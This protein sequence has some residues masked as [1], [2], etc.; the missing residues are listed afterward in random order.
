MPDEFDF[1]GQRDAASWKQ[2]GNGVNTGVVAQA[3]LGQMRRDGDL[4][5]RD[6]RGAAVLEAVSSTMQTTGGDLRGLIRESVLRGQ[7][8]SSRLAS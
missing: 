8:G 4:L 1:T 7:D 3:L 5:V 2:L 6:P